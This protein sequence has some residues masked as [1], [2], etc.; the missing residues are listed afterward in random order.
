[1]TSIALN[2]ISKFRVR[3][4]PSI[5]EYQRR[6]AKFPEHLV[7]AFAMLLRF[8]RVGEPKDDPA[9][10]DIIRTA[11]LRDVLRNTTL[12]GQSLEFLYE[13]VAQYENS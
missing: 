8:Y 12:W 10:I 4:L 7:F 3:V 2:S 6:F 13:E 1:M 11:P 5:L 9:L